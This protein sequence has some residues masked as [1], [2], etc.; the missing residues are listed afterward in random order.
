[1]RWERLVPSWQFVNQVSHGRGGSRAEHEG[2]S[3]EGDHRDRKR[4]GS[5][6]AALACMAAIAGRHMHAV[7]I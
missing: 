7:R 3:E 4:N 5:A 2:E 1:M 6:A